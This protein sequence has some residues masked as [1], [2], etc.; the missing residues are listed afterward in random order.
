MAELLAKTPCDGLLPLS[1]GA[2]SVEEALFGAITSVAPFKGQQAAVSAELQKQVGV[3]LPTPNRSTS[4]DQVRVVFSGQGQALV[5]GAALD[6]IPG[7][8]MT[9]QSDAWA[10]VTVSGAGALDVLARLVP[11]DLRPAVFDI[12]HVARTLVGHMT[13][14]VFKIG[15]DSFGVLVFRSMAHTLV[16]ELKTAMAGVAARR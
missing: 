3:G 15:D 16:H 5:L 4:S 1:I 10:C 7:A 8:A 9:D 6:P 2:V 14:V 11:V 13:A 12:G